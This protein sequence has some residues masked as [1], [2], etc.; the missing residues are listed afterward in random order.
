[1][2]IGIVFHIDNNHYVAQ[3]RKPSNKWF[4]ANDENISRLPISEVGHLGPEAHPAML[5]LRRIHQGV[6]ITIHSQ[7]I[8]NSFKYFPFQ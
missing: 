4:L 5:V 8:N 1:M 2:V 3:I 7:L 6:I